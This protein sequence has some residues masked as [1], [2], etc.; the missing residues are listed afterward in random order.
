MP[1][2]LSHKHTSEFPRSVDNQNK[3]LRM[4]LERTPPPTCIYSALEPVS[5]PSWA[6][7]HVEP[8]RAVGSL[9]HNTARPRSAELVGCT[10]VYYHSPLSGPVCHPNAVHI[11]H[12][13][14]LRAHSPTCPL[15]TGPTS[16]KVMASTLVPLGDRPGSRKP[17]QQGQ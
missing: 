4:L 8:E 1:L 7:T 6:Q 13:P 11:S 9:L 5:T 2:I 10:E 17:T 3:T 14:N 15:N 16:I 12:C